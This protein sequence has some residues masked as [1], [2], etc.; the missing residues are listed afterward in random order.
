MF[1]NTLMTLHFV[2]EVLIQL[3]DNLTAIFLEIIIGTNQCLSD[4]ILTETEHHK[5]HEDAIYCSSIELD[6][7]IL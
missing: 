7:I 3:Y 2:V 1:L 6:W 5:L 4:E